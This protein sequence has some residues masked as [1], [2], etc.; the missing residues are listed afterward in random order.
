MRYLRKHM[1]FI[2]FVGI[3]LLLTLSPIRNNLSQMNIPE[4][5]KAFAGNPIAPFIYI[6]FYILGVIFAFPGLPLTVLSGAMFG[7]GVGTLV[8]VIGSNLGIQITFLISRYFGGELMPF[9]I[10]RYPYFKEM[11]QRLNR[12]GFRVMVT[13]RLLP[14]IPF[15]AINYLSGLTSVAYK[16][17][18]MGN[19]IGM[20]PASMLYVYFGATAMES[21]GNPFGLILSIIMIL[22]FTGVSTVIKKKQSKKA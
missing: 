17:Y 7:F 16:D 12:N 1:K 21:Q 9:I 18:T 15:N 5:I 20:L 13:L 10:R 19:L 14:I 11:D 6:G 22:I 3:I 8:T 4:K 2:V